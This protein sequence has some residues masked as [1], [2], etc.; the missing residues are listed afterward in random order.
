MVKKGS[1]YIRDIESIAF[2]RVKYAVQTL[3][4]NVTNTYQDAPSS[5]PAMFFSQRDNPSVYEDL[6]G[7]ENAV[8]PMIEIQS[9]TKGTTAYNDGKKIHNLSDK[10]MRDMGFR[11]TF[12]PQQVTNLSDTSITRVISRYT[13][14]IASGDSI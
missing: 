12:G 3:C 4:T 6:S 2:T 10:A 14:I 13:R 9:Y 5:F 1:D 11:R 7:I 8:E